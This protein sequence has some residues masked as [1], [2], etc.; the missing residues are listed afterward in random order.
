MDNFLVL[1]G[2]GD[3]ICQNWFSDKLLLWL[4]FSKFLLPICFFV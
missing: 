1:F 4:T 3:A 2:N